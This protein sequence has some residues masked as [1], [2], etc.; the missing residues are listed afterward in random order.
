MEKFTIADR[1]V[2]KQVN[3][4]DNKNDF[5]FWKTQPFEYRLKTL[6]NIGEE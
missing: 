1:N 6:E 5:N 3:I 2:I 4:K